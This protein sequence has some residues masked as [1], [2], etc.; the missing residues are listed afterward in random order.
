MVQV[1]WSKELG[2]RSIVASNGRHKGP[3]LPRRTVSMIYTVYMASNTRYKGIGLVRRTVSIAIYMG[4]DY[5]PMANTGGF[6]WQ[7]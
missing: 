6:Q 3:G 2:L 1:R 7:M 4:K 5:S